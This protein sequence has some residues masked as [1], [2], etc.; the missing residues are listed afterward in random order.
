METPTLPQPELH[1]QQ[2]DAGAIPAEHYAELVDKVE[3][4]DLAVTPNGLLVSDHH[5]ELA[6][7]SPMARSVPVTRTVAI[8]KN[9]ALRHRFDIEPRIQEASFE[10][11]KERQMEFDVETD[12]DALYELFGDDADSLAE[13]PVW[14]YVLERKRAV[15]VWNTLMGNI[16]PDV[17]RVEAP[18]SLRALYGHSREQ[19]ALMGSPDTQTAEIQISALFASSPPFRSADLPAETEADRYDNIRTS[20]LEALQAEPSEAGEYAASTN[21]STVN[22]SNRSGGKPSFK[23][24]AIP[25]TNSEPDIV[26][27]MSRAAALRITGS[28]VPDR[29]SPSKPRTPLTKERLAQTFANVPGHKRAETIA[30]ASTAPPTIA[31]RMT[32]AAALRI[33]KDQAT[34][35]GR[36]GPVAPRL[37]KRSVTDGAVSAAE[38]AEKARTT[39]DGIPGHKRRETI[40]V[41]SVKP[42][43]VTPRSNKSATLRQSIG[44]GAAPPSSFRGTVAPTPLSRTPSTDS[45]TARRQSAPLTASTPT[46]RA[47]SALGVR[48]PSSATLDSEAGTV[49]GTSR[50]PSAAAKLRPRPSSVTLP[51]AITPRTNKSAALRA[52]KME[53]EAAAAAKKKAPRSS[54]PPPSSFK[55][56]TVAT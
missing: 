54:K 18:N 1:V 37:T 2:T 56:S 51:P 13:G 9:H 7:S 17:A 20:I 19:N 25:S 10:I 33:A 52:A 8:I 23:A 55:P 6:P 16:D 21:A 35:G 42:P 53:A 27:R 49:A 31:P 15:E 29:V 22:D 11:V 30:V 32:K 38:R 3:H 14:V 34:N 46:R 26:P 24:R 45:M 40:S 47:S 5:Q 43:T 41:A 4:P 39:F 50:P 28:T 36:P 48:T 12:P 44:G